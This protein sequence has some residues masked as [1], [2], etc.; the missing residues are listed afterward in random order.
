MVDFNLA[1]V[2]DPSSITMTMLPNDFRNAYA[3]AYGN[4]WEDARETLF[5]CDADVEI[6]HT[7]ISEFQKHGKFREKPKVQLPMCD[8]DDR[9]EYNAEVANGMHRTIALIALS[10]PIEFSVYYPYLPVEDVFTHVKL[11]FQENITEDDETDIFGWL[12]SMPLDSNEWVET[13]MGSFSG[14]TYR[15]WLDKVVDHKLLLKKI[16]SL[17]VLDEFARLGLTKID[18]EDIV[19]EDEEPCPRSGTD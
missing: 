1:R 14:N 5:N 2:I 13:Y 12:R 11:V 17:A 8:L 7:L 16:H 10:K 18:I 3:P 15:L 6:I 19:D 4:S 9:I